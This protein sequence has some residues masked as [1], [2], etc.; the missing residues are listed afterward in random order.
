MEKPKQGTTP[1]IVKGG[2]GGKR[3]VIDPSESVQPKAKAEKRWSEAF[4]DYCRS[5]CHLAENTVKAYER[6]LKRFDHWLAN[7]HVRSLTV[8]DLSDYMGA[9][10]DEGL[11]PSSIARTIVA[12]RMYFKFLQLE[13]V[14][15]ENRAE[16]LGSQKL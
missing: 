3:V 9:L 15:V 6:D 4:L 10:S 1:K 13:G 8:A 7:R 12:M 16:L 11:A 2:R 14:L 5:E